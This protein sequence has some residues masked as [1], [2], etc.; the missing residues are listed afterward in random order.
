[1]S[2]RSVGRVLPT[3]GFLI[4]LRER[5]RLLKSGVEALKMK[6][7]QL[8]RECQSLIPDLKRRSDIERKLEDAYK[9]LRLA[10]SAAGPEEMKKAALLT[11]P[12]LTEMRVRS[13]IGVEVPET[14]VI[15]LSLA[16]SP[17]LNAVVIA[18]SRKFADAIREMMPLVNSEA[19]FERIATALSDTMRKVNALE[20][21][22]IPDH[23]AAIRYI[24][25]MLE[26]E[27]LEE[28]IMVKKYREIKR[29][30]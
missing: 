4:R 9:I 1:M 30:E 12:L 17:S 27:S 5:T 14:K 28:F 24:E 22:V 2:F 21:I 26:E 7:D 16:T 13:V 29:G 23:E 6:R 20:K 8:V 11:T 15:G 25:E 10:Y 3:K 19:K 18:A